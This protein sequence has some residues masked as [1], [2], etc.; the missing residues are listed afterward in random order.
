[1][2]QSMGPPKFI[3]VNRSI[4]LGFV[5]V[6]R[7]GYLTGQ[8]WLSDSCI[9]KAGTTHQSW[10]PTAHRSTWRQHWGVFLQSESVNWN[11][12]RS[13]WLVFAA[14]RQLLWSES[15]LFG[16]FILRREGPTA[17]GL[18]QELS[19]AILSCLPSCLEETV[20]QHTHMAAHR[21]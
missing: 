10:E 13:S 3:L 4:L 7:K 20:P 14:S 9:T 16:L 12:F 18:F 15:S 17:S 11:L 5:D 2:D 1:M 21:C 6:S 19:E 8:N